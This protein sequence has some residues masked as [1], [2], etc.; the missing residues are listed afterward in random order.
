[1]ILFLFVKLKRSGGEHIKINIFFIKS[2]KKPV[3]FNI[4][5][6]KMY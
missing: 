1:M 4:R 2:N 5:S 3:K 6:I